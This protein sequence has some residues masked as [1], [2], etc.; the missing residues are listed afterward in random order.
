[1]G[2]E[3]IEKLN[4]FEILFA[5]Q[6]DRAKRTDEDIYTKET[7]SILLTEA[8]ENTNQKFFYEKQG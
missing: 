8:T 5:S 3:I 6:I 1:M 4:K 7:D 2:I